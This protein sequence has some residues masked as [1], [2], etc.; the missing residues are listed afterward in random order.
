MTHSEII[1]DLCSWLKTLGAHCESEFLISNNWSA[2]LG[3]PII[4]VWAYGHAASKLAFMAFEVKAQRSDLL[5]DIRSEKYKKY[6][7][8]C[9]RFY[10][11]YE[12]GLAKP[13][14][15]PKPAGI[16]ERDPE[17]GWK[18]VRQ[19]QPLE[20]PNL[21]TRNMEALLR[22]KIP[23]PKTPELLTGLSFGCDQKSKKEENGAPPSGW[24]E[25]EF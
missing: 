14:E 7:P 15:I 2:P 3:F 23:K 8:F 6:L 19:A 20:F 10:F 18:L 21:T 22:R 11:A 12:S 25:F 13:T 1:N 17:T 24:P 9:S 5:Q 4:D 16:V